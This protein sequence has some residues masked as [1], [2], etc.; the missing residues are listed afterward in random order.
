M[1]SLPMG[2]MGER[3]LTRIVIDS[4]RSAE[5]VDGLVGLSAVHIDNTASPPEIARRIEVLRRDGIL[6]VDD[7]EVRVTEF[8]ERYREELREMGESRDCTGDARAYRRRCVR[9]DHG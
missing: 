1:L 4:A 2:D 6:R 9:V 8:G 7:G 3:E 5:S